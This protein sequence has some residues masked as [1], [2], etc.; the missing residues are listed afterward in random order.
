MKEYE[1]EGNVAFTAR[2]K[3]KNFGGPK[4]KGI[5]LVA[6]KTKEEQG[7]KG[8]KVNVT[9]VTRLATMS[10]N[11][12]SRRI[13]LMMMRT[14]TG[15]MAIKGTTSSKERGRLPLVAMEIGN[16]S[17]GQEIPSMRNLMLLM[18]KEMNSFLYL[19]SLL[20]LHPTL[21]MSG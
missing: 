13:L 6:Q 11:A 20:H 15:G 1:N 21:W 14:S 10:E 9:H 16:L 12:L 5:T 2:A 4:N 18:I 8:R 19:P 7:P 3:K 17:K